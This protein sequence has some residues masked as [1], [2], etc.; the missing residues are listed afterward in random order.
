[1]QDFS[2]FKKSLEMIEHYVYALCENDDERRI[3]FYIGNDVNDRCTL[4]RTLT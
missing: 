2:K 4:K 3:P 1:M